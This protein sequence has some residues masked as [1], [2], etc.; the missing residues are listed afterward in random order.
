MKSIFVLA[1]VV[2]SSTVTADDPVATL[3]TE[4]TGLNVAAPEADAER[5]IAKGQA[6]CFSVN[7]YAKYFPGVPE[8]DQE[9]CQA[10]EK[11][12][13]GTWDV[14]LTEEH[15]ELISRAIK[16]A[17]RYNAFVLHHRK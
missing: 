3:R 11:N 4:L 13:R 12:F 10:R 9:Y 7:A 8:Q 14:V 5:D 17:E 15:K 6:V 1:L 2:A 16:Y